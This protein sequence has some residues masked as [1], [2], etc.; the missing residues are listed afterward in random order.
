MA[1]N[2]FSARPQGAGRP[3]RTLLGT[4][5]EGTRPRTQLKSIF[6]HLKIKSLH[7]LHLAQG[8]RLYQQAPWY[9]PDSAWSSI[10]AVRKPFITPVDGGEAGVPTSCSGIRLEG[11]FRDT[12]AGLH[13]PPALSALSR[14]RTTPRHSHY[15][16]DSSSTLLVCFFPTARATSQTIRSTG[17]RAA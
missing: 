2:A 15:D 9:H 5:Q 12:Q 14:S 3:R 10:G 1:Q 16:F 11:E 7:P 8:R 13:H 6:S 17:P 4:S